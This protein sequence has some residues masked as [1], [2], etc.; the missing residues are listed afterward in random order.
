MPMKKLRE[1][2][3]GAVN[4]TLWGFMQ[5]T[6]EAIALNKDYEEDSFTAIEFA[7]EYGYI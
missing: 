6:A 3:N 7:V 2:A 5:L 1:F 4:G